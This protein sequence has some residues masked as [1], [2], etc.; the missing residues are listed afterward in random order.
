MSI[1]KSVSLAAKTSIEPFVPAGTTAL[2]VVTRPGK[3]PRML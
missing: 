1:I 3:A 2:I